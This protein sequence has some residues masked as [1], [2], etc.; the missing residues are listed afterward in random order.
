[1]C[2]TRMLCV[3]FQS[4]LEMQVFEKLTAMLK[5]MERKTGKELDKDI[6]RVNELIKV[7][8]KFKGSYI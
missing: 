2:R 3:I 1:M 7:S 6:N 8:Y 4:D 5:V